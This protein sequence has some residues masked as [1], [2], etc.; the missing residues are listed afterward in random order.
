MDII[1]IKKKLE[2]ENSYLKKKFY[3]NKIGIFGSFVKGKQKTK[4]DL[5]IL[6]IFKK[7]H[8]DFFNYMRL[9]FYLEQKFGR[10]VDIVIKEAIKPRLKEKILNEVEY[11]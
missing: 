7:G 5:D 3:V 6:I 10:K 8:K 9:K 2:I 1:E 4:S 11:V